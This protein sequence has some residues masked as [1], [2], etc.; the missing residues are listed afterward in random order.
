MPDKR[1]TNGKQADLSFW[2]V[3]WLAA[4]DTFLRFEVRGRSTTDSGDLLGTKI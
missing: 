2:V 4:S 3:V 1:G